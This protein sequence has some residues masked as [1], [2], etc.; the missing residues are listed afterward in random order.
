MLGRQGATAPVLTDSF[1][2]VW[3]SHSSYKTPQ[4]FLLSYPCFAGT[5]LCFTRLQAVPLTVLSGINRHGQ[6]R[7]LYTII[8]TN[9]A[10]WEDSLFHRNASQM[11]HNNIHKK[12]IFGPARWSVAVYTHFVSPAMGLPHCRFENAWEW[13]ENLPTPVFIVPSPSSKIPVEF[14][15]RPD[16]VIIFY[17]YFINNTAGKKTYRDFP[18]AGK[19]EY[20]S[21]PAS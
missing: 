5:K 8:I 10:V 21:G 16:T 3:F 15:V 18:N 9:S 4:K 6:S 7:L 19:L 2:E 11:H 13:G 14:L 17:V 1:Q 12:P 20:F